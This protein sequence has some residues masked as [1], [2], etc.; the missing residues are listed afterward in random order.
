MRRQLLLI[1][2]CCVL[3]VPPSSEAVTLQRSEAVLRL[4]DL[5]RRYSCQALERKVLDIFGLI[6]ATDTSVRAT[7][8]EAALGSARSPQLRWQFDFPPVATASASHWHT[9]RIQPGNPSS[10]DVADCVLLR[11]LRP[12]LPGMVTGYRLDCRAPQFHNP[13]FYVDLRAP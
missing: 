12:Y 3:L 2:S 11:R 7:R 6:G 13:A 10:L 1:I 9:V 8:C 5:P 4:G